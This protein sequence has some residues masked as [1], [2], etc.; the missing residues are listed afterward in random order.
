MALMPRVLAT[1]GMTTAMDMITITRM[2][3]VR[4]SPL[5]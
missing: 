2:A 1:M 4:S 3:P 5:S